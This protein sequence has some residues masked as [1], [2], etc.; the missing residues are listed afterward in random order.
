MAFGTPLSK[1]ELLP[2][3]TDI[4][5]GHAPSNEQ[6]EALA[7]R[8]EAIG[9][10]SPLAKI[11][12][13]QVDA[14]AQLLQERQI[15][16]KVALGLAHTAPKIQTVVNQLVAAGVTKIYGLPLAAQY[17]SFNSQSYHR[18]VKAALANHHDVEYHPVDGF[19]DQPALVNYWVQ[20]LHA[21]Q[22]I[23]DKPDTTVLFSAHSLPEKV[24]AAGD[25]YKENVQ[26]SVRLIA[27]QAGLSE[28]QYTLGWQSAGKT[29]D[30]WIGPRF[31]EVA[32]HLLEAGKR[33]IISAPIGFIN[34]NLEINY[35]VD[36]AL[37]KEI[38]E[39]NGQ[40]L[41]LPMP[42]AGISLATAVCD[43]L[44]EAGLK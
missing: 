22:D 16:V 42:N 44:R 26:K 19:G 40:L 18:A 13:D 41:R 38:E 8:Y 6:L 3:Y 29:N 35:D 14:V 37:R 5:H 15:N 20:R 39:N 28:G 24:L 34:D 2:Y 25:P 12:N 4:R 27:E 1:E 7:A 23:I 43:R 21:H 10:L 17:S 36:I 9:G 11:T 33:Q 32:K 30:A 31:E